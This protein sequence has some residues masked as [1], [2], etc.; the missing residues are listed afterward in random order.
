MPDA[1]TLC[2][3]DE[4]GDGRFQVRASFQTTQGGGAAGNAQAISLAGLGITFGGVMWFFSA[5]NPELLVKILPSGCATNGFFWVFASA[6]TNLGLVIT[7]TDLATGAEK[8]YTNP[9]VN[10]M[11]PIQDT[12]AFPC[13]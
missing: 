5:D 4:P 7:V 6:G 1:T 3:D 12:T 10:P 11:A 8:V 13:G 2:I 9:D